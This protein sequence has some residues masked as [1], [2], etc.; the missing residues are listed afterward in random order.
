MTAFEERERP[1]EWLRGL[2]E[3]AAGYSE[4]LRVSGEPVKAAYRIA[5]ARCRTRESAASIP[6]VREVHAAIVELFRA[7]DVPTPMPSRAA[8]AEECDHMGLA[9]I[10][11]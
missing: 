9:L 2:R 4:L 3:Q 8:I 11:A 7:A 5:A 10:G 1:S 6:T